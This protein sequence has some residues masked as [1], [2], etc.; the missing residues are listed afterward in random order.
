MTRFNRQRIKAA[1]RAEIRTET[2]ELFSAGAS[3]QLALHGRWP[4]A[5]RSARTP[6]APVPGPLTNHQGGAGWQRDPRT[7]LFVLA[8]THFSGQHSFYES[9]ADRE[10]RFTTLVRRFALEDPSWALGLLRWLRNQAQ[11]RSAA[12]AGAVEFARARA[13]A[14]APGHSRQAVDAVL[15]RP[16]EPGEFLA[17]WTAR[18]GRRLPQPVRRGLGD[19]ARRLYTARAVLKYD[20]PSHA[21]RF[22][23]VLELTHPAPAADRPRQGELFRY[24]LDRRHHLHRAVPP[25][26]EPVLAAREQLAAL[27]LAERPAVLAAPDAAHRLAAAGMTWEALAGWLQGPMDAAAWEAV[28]PSMGTMALVRNLRNFDRAGIGDEAASLVAARITDPEQVAR[29]RQLPFRFLAAHRA[30]PGPRWAAA[31]ETALGHSL[32]NVPHLPGRTLVLVDRSGSMFGVPESR[33]E[34]TRAD[35]AAVFGSALALRADRADLVEFGTDSR[36]V[37][38]APDE[39]LL[40]TVERFHDLGGTDTAGAVARH[41]DG[42]HRVVVITDE[43]PGLFGRFDPFASVP[44]DVPVYTW[45]LCGYR[46]G[47]A[48]PA[49]NR[50]VFGGLSDAAFRLVPLLEAGGAEQWPWEPPVTSG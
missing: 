5:P 23:D 30:A 20:T 49:P 12:V 47:H 29:S 8:V 7:E 18:Y 50:H 11:I 10:E 31:L 17:L 3:G 48:P 21:F 32:A 43:Q 27:P 38:P 1:T 39:S 41:F 15:Q 35:A 24:V 22:A 19:A 14:R 2:P 34:L 9:A 44:P 37:E 6:S 28:I 16:D 45:N 4:L 33:T 40:T 46:T 13:E 42:H 25:R 26:D 36:P